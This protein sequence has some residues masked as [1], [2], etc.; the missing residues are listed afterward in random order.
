MPTISLFISSQHRGDGC[1]ILFPVLAVTGRWGSILRTGMRDPAHRGS[2]KPF[3]DRHRNPSPWLLHDS[4]GRRAFPNPENPPSRL[5]KELGGSA[6]AA[7]QAGLRPP[8]P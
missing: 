8:H 5:V 3:T 1:T 6:A 2:T 7:A 4:S